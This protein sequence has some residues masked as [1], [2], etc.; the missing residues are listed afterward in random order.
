MVSS[1]VNV[2]LGFALGKH[3]VKYTLEHTGKG[4]VTLILDVP[5]YGFKE[6]Q[7][8][9]NENNFNKIKQI[10]EIL[11]AYQKLVAIKKDFPIMVLDNPTFDLNRIKSITKDD[12]L[13]IFS[14]FF[15]VKAGFDIAE[16]RQ[17]IQSLTT[18]L[19]IEKS[20]GGFL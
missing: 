9:P 20:S 18:A 6:T 8:K 12:S 15:N 1:V 17:L 3:K 10:N 4:Y 7:I 19:K 14:K 2:D 5:P 13:G 16:I 11:D